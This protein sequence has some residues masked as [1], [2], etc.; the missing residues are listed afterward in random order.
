MLHAVLPEG[1]EVRVEEALL[2]FPADKREPRHELVCGKTRD[3]A[4]GAGG[5]SITFGL[6]VHG[7][8]PANPEQQVIL[9]GGLD[10]GRNGPTATARG[11]EERDE[12]RAG[13]HHMEQT[14][15]DDDL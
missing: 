11:Q 5:Q 15:A 2:R 9:G 8:I 12:D 6:T 3:R 10:I 7:R 13:A 14:P 1:R 4:K